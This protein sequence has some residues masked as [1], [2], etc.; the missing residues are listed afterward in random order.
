MA[1]EVTGVALSGGEGRRVG[2]AD[3]G[4]MTLHGREF[5]DYVLSEMTTLCSTTLLSINRNELA[6]RSIAERYENVS[7]LFDRPEYAHQ[8]PLS[9]LLV[10][11]ENATTSHV[12][13]CPC[14]TPFISRDLF[15]ALLKMA[16]ASP[17]GA[18]Y[19]QA[20]NKTHPLHAI[21]PVEAALTQLKSFLQQGDRRVMKFLASIQALPLFW[22]NDD[23]LINLN[24]G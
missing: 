13:V 4:L 3:K 5:V 16:Q 1:I 19:I 11:L 24:Y 22:L 23:E 12:L 9:G 20:H 2:G 6:Y 18:F 17:A 15:A 21:L 7:L 10:A 8:G 14:D